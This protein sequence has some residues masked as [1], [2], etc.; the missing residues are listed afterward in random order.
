MKKTLFPCFIASCQY[1]AFPFVKTALIHR[2]QVIFSGITPLYLLYKVQTKP[3]QSPN[4]VL[5]KG[6]CL[7][8]IWILNTFCHIFIEWI[9]PCSISF[10][11]GTGMK[12]WRGKWNDGETWIHFSTVSFLHFFLSLSRYDVNK[13]IPS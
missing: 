9:V 3:K 12:E 6:L 2:K 10:L 4:K 7:Q 8:F 1:S 13:R 11:Y 5:R